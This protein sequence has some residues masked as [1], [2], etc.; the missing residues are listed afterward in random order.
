MTKE[1]MFQYMF[2]QIKK[3]KGWD[4]GYEEIY[5]MEKSFLMGIKYERIMNGMD[6]SNKIE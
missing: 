6:E 1:E 2:E 3:Q 5:L 4:L